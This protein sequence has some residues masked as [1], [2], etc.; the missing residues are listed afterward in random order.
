MQYKEQI[1]NYVQNHKEE[2]I[3]ILKELIKIPSVRG[4]AEENAPFGKECARILEFTKNL[5]KNNGFETELDQNGGYL[6][7]FF[8]KG[9]KSLGVFA[10]ADVVPVSDDWIYT[11]PFE[12]IEKDGCIIG[13]GALD[14]KSAVIISLYCAKILKELNIPFGSRLVMFTGSNEESGMQ[15]IKNY[16][17]SHIPPDFSF[18]ADTAFPLYRGNKGILR[19]T[20]KSNTPL[21]EITDFC[22]GSAFNVILGEASLKYNN[23]L[24]TEKGISK[25]AALPEGSV[26]AGYL[27]AKKLSETDKLNESDKKQ[28]VFVANLLE[29]YYGEIFDIENLDAD[30]GRL[31]VANGIIK[32]DDQR[33]TLSFDIRYGASADIIEAKEKI[34]KFFKQNNWSVDFVQEAKAFIINEDNSYITKCL[35][36]YREFT[37]DITAQSYINAGGTYARYL[38]CAAEVGTVLTNG[39]DFDLPTGH[40]GVHQPDEY[41]NINGLLDAIELILL[42]LIECDK[43]EGKR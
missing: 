37:G 8:G 33:L 28:M 19:F 22:G 2:I 16:L 11:K 18:V 32:T 30:F 42:M 29:K 40:G 24:Y 9:E 1:H 23:V 4:E 35:N 14:D 39:R 6:L 34:V 3:E 38:P 20:A 7:S 25:H 43:A 5:Y 26:N 13:R 12:P 21:K 15:D 36:I 10:H 27:L 41:M 17:S 31:T